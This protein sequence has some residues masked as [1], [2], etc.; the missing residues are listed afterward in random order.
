MLILSR[1]SCL[2]ICWK[3]FDVNPCCDAWFGLK[4]VHFLFLLR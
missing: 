2:N 3:E 1:Q 4:G